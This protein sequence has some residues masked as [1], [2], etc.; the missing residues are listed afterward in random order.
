MGPTGEVIFQTHQG[1]EAIPR[2][3]LPIVAG[4]DS[5]E[6]L[7]CCQLSR[8]TAASS[9][10]S[11]CLMLETV[12]SNEGRREAVCSLPVDDPEKQSAPKS[13]HL[14]HPKSLERERAP[15]IIG[16]SSAYIHSGIHKLLPFIALLRI[17]ELFC[18]YCGQKPTACPAWLLIKTFSQ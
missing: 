15:G 7:P 8:F 5:S 3:L 4:V 17:F 1:L 18:L 14:G 11:E 9:R 6:A 16:T 10:S 12:G 13:R 2:S